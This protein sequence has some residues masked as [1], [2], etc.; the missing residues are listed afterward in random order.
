MHENIE[1]ESNEPPG[2][3]LA[4]W[5]ESLYLINLLVVPGIGFLGQI[6]LYRGMDDTTP[7]LARAH[8]QQT[9]FASLWAG[10]LLVAVN[11]LIIALG[12]YDAPYTWVVVIT[13]FTV[14][15]STLVLLGMLGLAKAM[16]GRCLRF[17]LVGGPL[18]P[19]CR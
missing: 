4:I 9:L 10:V 3:P 2:V 5:A 8:I 19:G 6:W 1:P 17:P 15:H 7:P 16:A 18:P 11:L 13:Y 14:C 12:G